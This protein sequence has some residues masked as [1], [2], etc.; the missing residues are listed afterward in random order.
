[1]V[2]LARSKRLKGETDRADFKRKTSRVNKEE[3]ELE[4]NDVVRRY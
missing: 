1:M 4:K 2:K 3:V